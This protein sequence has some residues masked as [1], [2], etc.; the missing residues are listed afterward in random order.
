MLVLHK[1]ENNNIIFTGAARSKAIA[2]ML[3]VALSLGFA[4]GKWH[5]GGNESSPVAKSVTVAA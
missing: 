2:P 5:L 3:A 4:S 1:F